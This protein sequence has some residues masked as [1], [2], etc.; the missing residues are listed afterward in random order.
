MQLCHRQRAKKLGDDCASFPG[1]D[2]AQVKQHHTI[3]TCDVT[4]PKSKLLVYDK[5]S[6]KNILVDTGADISV[7]PPEK[8][9]DRK[10]DDSIIPLYAANGSDIAV[11]GTKRIAP[12]LGLRRD[13]PVEF[14][15]GR[16]E[17]PDHWL[18]FSIPL[19]F[20][21]RL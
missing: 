15:C 21:G 2:D 9:T 8:E 16:C 6:G 20:I 11:Y 19:R 14:R 12:D 18:R 4:Q 1:V 5:I 7:M 13:L 17:M 3:A 10:R